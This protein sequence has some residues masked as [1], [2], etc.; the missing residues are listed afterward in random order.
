MAATIT[1]DL[2]GIR[3]DLSDSIWDVSPIEVPFSSG[4]KRVSVHNTT[5]EWQVDEL[6]A[7]S[8]TV[9]TEGADKTKTAAAKTVLLNNVTEI[10][11][12]DASVS[13]TVEATNRAGRGKEM[14]YQIVKR[15]KEIK[16]DFE[17]HLVGLHQI[18]VTGSAR[19]TASYQVWI[20]ENDVSNATAGYV[21]VTQTDGWSTG[22][23]APTEGTA[24]SLTEASLRTAIE[25]CWNSGGN[26]DTIMCNAF[27]KAVIN[28]FGGNA[29]ATQLDRAGKV[30]V[31]TVDVY[32]SSYGR[33]SVVPN[34]FVKTS[35]VL[36]YEKS[37][38]KI[39]V[40]R[41]MQ[42][43]PLAKLGD[44]EHRQVLMEAGLMACNEHSSSCIFSNDLV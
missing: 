39:G 37:K 9:G 16:R 24:G 26:P 21:G 44:S 33:L 32:L 5:F 31:D 8:A 19:K 20:S 38:W 42:N 12:K 35:D 14:T 11:E 2:A 22:G 7:K 25:N 13:G 15:A 18:K 30:V 27:Q 3:E 29:N 23:N 40:L 34:R 41:G 28:G 1:T 17:H 36:V 43:K 10:I 4:C 6:A